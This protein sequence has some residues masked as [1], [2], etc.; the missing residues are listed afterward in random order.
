MK[1]VMTLLVRDEIDIIAANLDFH[2]DRGVDLFIVADN[3]SVDGTT[4]A[5]RRYE[6][7]GLVHY[8][9]QSGD[10]FSQHRW[11][12]E[13]ARL[14]YTEFGAD[15][16]INN[17][18]DEFW[19][20][21]AGTLKDVLAVIDPAAEAVT[22]PRQN[23]LPRPFKTGQ[24]FADAMTIRERVP[25][26]F[27]GKPLPPKTLH[28]GRADIIV[29]QGNHSVWRNGIPIAGVSAP[30]EVLHF[31]V[32]SRSQFVSKIR[33]GGSGYARNT[34][35]PKS[36]GNVKRHL[37]DLYQAGQ[38]DA[39]YDAMLVGDEELRRGLTDG[40]LVSDERMKQ[41]MEALSVHTEPTAP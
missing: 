22:V 5:L 33:N 1:L 6:R 40:R 8:I 30:I 20:P 11:V 10:D 12:T 21:E 32:R 35:L 19:Y 17:D 23:F 37:Y 3:L 29:G 18:A 15:W 41:A 34:E 13:M 16:V 38:L 28:R 24:S 36:V 26:N 27:V 14:A 7:R 25:L 9:E 2:A 31:P 39:F 4:D